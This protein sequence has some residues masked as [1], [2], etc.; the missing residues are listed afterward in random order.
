MSAKKKATVEAGY[1]ARIRKLKDQRDRAAAKASRLKDK[2]RRLEKAAADAQAEIKKLRKR[3]EREPRQIRPHQSTQSETSTQPTS[4]AIG[5]TQGALPEPSPG[6]S[7]SRAR[8]DASWTVV[9]LRAE[10]RS[11]G[12]TGLSGRS[13]A[14]LIAALTEARGGR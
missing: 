13:K 12:I 1:K 5:E 6:V 7:P 3:L 8:P 4:P 11:R 9:Q 14:D 10:A 2:N